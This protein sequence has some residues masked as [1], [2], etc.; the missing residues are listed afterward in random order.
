MHLKLHSIE[1][2][3]SVCRA[4]T[5][6]RFGVASVERATSLVARVEL[7]L[8]DGRRGVGHAADLCM[9]RWFRKDIE[10]TPQ[11]DVEALLDAAR[12]ARSSWLARAGAAGSLFEHWWAVYS[13]RVDA[14][15]FEHP[16]RLERGFGVALI[17][18]AAIDALCHALQLSFFEVLRGGQLG[19]EPGRVHP[20]LEGWSLAAS[21][22]SEPRAEVELRHTIGL[23]DALRSSELAGSERIGD[24]EPESLEEYVRDHARSPSCSTGAATPSRA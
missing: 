13:E 2:G 12:A 10:R 7:E 21:L 14:L 15:P 3:T 16:E 6:F 18:R 19:F 23:G 9:P 5:P 1:L 8:A 20:E 22:P 24:G 4:R 17:E 11:A